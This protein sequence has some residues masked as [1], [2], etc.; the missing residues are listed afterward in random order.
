MIKLSAV[1][2]KASKAPVGTAVGNLT[3]YDGSLKALPAGFILDE[4]A[5]GF[6]SVSNGAIVTVTANLPVGFYTVVVSAVAMS[7]DQW[8]EEK[9]FV[10]QVQ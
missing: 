1:S 6:F 2:V 4:G 9:T 5:A 7:A 10:I 3:L 8:S